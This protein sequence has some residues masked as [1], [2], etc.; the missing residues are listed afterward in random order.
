MGGFSTIKANKSADHVDLCPRSSEPCSGCENISISSKFPRFEYGLQLLKFPTELSPAAIEFAVSP[1]YILIEG[2]RRRR[3][4]AWSWYRH[5]ELSI[6]CF[7][8]LNA[9]K[10]RISSPGIHFTGKSNL[11]SQFK[12]WIS[13][14][15]S[16]PR[17][18]PRS[19]ILRPPPVPP[20][21]S[22][23]KTFIASAR[24]S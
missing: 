12:S 9:V 1:C 20:V 2:A 22:G 17:G 6:L 8:C 19:A 5:L 13:N 7:A 16:H 23:H 10:K 24:L 3:T 4:G 14:A 11:S 15:I 21:C 18:G